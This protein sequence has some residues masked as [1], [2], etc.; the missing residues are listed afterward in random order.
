M[1]GVDTILAWRA[2]PIK[3]TIE[4]FHVQPDRWQMM[5]LACLPGVH[6]N[7]ILAKYGMPPVP[8][9][10]FD[11][12][13]R[14]SLQAC[15]GPGKSA[16][17]AWSGWWM[18][19]C[20]GGKGEHPKGAAISMNRDNLRDAL[21]SEMSRWQS[22]SEYLKGM[23]E[24]TKEKIFAKDHPETW[25]LSART[26][27][28][29]ADKES[30]GRV[31]SGLH[32]KYIFYL[33]DESGD[34]N[35]MVLKSCEQGLSN[36]TVGLIIQ[37]GN[38]TSH[39]GMLYAANNDPKWRVISITAD[40]RDPNRT[41]RVSIEWAQGMID[42]FGYDDPWVMA[43]ILGKFP[44]TSLHSLLSIE[45]VEAA[46][47][48]GRG[49]DPQLY[50]SSQKRIGVDVARQGLDTTVL[51]PRQGFA[52]WT[53]VEM[54]GA[55]STAVAEQLIVGKE[56]WGSELEFVDGTGGYGA[57]VVDAYHARGYS[58]IEVQFA[59]QAADKE[60]FFNKRAEIWW[61]M[62]QWIK[63]GGGIPDIPQLKQELVAVQYGYQGGRLKIEEKE[64]IKKRLGFSPDYADALAT[65]FAIPERAATPVFANGPGFRSSGRLIPGVGEEYD[66]FH[67]A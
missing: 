21:W 63:R 10:N 51:F 18:L 8:D 47:L 7:E 26:Y 48:R 54:R 46:V 43:Y 57:G 2:D 22:E 65:T 36:C 58:C 53:P 14:I 31:L 16:D 11:L 64:Q 3:F 40:P 5:A 30:Q 55:R 66:P 56:K 6:T 61:H 35:P 32:S 41:P 28:K 44:P 19:G 42:K 25:F 20:W 13:K 27:N 15:A 29:D 1:A 60:S 33:V 38:C 37:A 17:L 39:D 12:V 67:D 50:E 34:T 62:A 59:G 9:E 45:D 24:W 52:S 49:M 4:N 23:F